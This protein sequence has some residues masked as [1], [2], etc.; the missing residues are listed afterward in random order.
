METKRCPYCGEEILAVA[1]KCKFCGEWL[2]ETSVPEQIDC[3]ICAER[4]DANATS[5]MNLS[6]RVQIRPNIPKHH[7]NILQTTL[8]AWLQRRILS[9]CH[10]ALM[11]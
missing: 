4:I 2:N 6:I 8:H 1:K 3:P 10:P 7:H 11:W 5:V 9:P